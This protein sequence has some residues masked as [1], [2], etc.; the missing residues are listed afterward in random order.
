[1]VK[2]IKIGDGSMARKT[3]TIIDIVTANNLYR[4]GAVPD[5]L[6]DTVKSIKF[7]NSLKPYN[8]GYQ[9]EGPCYVVEFNESNNKRLIPMNSVQDMC[10]SVE[11]VATNK[12]TP[13]P[14]MEAVEATGE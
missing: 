11:D 12:N 13:E 9:I 6:Q 5:G 7:H 1:M 8:S 14:D 3:V 10:I 2:N 4:V